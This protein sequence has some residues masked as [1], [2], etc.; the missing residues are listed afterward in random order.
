MEEAE[1]SVYEKSLYYLSNISVNLKLFQNTKFSKHH[2]HQVGH[3]CPS[4]LQFVISNHCVNLK[5]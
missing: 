5:L 1:W 2:H 4:S 3:I